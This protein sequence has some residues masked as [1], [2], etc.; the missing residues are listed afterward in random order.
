MRCPPAVAVLGSVLSLL[1]AAPGHGPA[2]IEGR[3]SLPKAEAPAASP[4][5]YPGQA[6]EVVPPDPPTAVVYLEGHF[7]P[8]AAPAGATTNEVLQS[9]T[10]FHP[11]LLP[12]RVGTAVAF[13]NGDN[14]YHNVFSYSKTKRFDLGRYRKEERPPP[15]VVFDK[16]GPVKL[17]CE[18]HQHMR[19]VILVL[20]TPYFTRTQANGRYRLEGLPAGNYVLK[21]WVDENHVYEKAVSLQ[22]G[23]HLQVDFGRP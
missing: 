17:Y 3:V 6:G 16:P 10:Q 1:C 8:G 20:D 19:G 13:P 12:V 22:A 21:A 7:P 11:A 9:G 23:Q 4:R 14:F 18:I 2:G 15:V 5:H